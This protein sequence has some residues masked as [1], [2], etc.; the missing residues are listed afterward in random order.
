MNL[1][2]REETGQ[3]NNKPFK[4]FH[5]SQFTKNKV[6]NKT[7]KMNYLTNES[8]LSLSFPQLSTGGFLT[9]YR[10]PSKLSVP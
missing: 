6:L 3:E 8:P 2:R 1:S 9:S 7:V 5:Q 10:G 4:T